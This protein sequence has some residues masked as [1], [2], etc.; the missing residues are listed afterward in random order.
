VIVPVI[1]ADRPNRLELR[2]QTGYSRNNALFIN[3]SRDMRL[4]KTLIAAA[5]ASV[6]AGH[7]VAGGLAPVAVEP[8]VVVP[9]PAPARSTWGIILPLLGVALLVALASS[10]SN[11]ETEEE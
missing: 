7:A 8:V 3:W 6:V 1:G 10:S 11:D 2:D 5:L 9:E 4:T